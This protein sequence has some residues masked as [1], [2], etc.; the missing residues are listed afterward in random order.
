MILK[1]KGNEVLIDKEDYFLILK[2]K[3]WGFN[4][5]YLCHYYKKLRRTKLLFF[6]RIVIHAPADK[7]VDHINGCKLDNRKVNLRICSYAQNARNLAKIEGGSSI[8]KGVCYNKKNNKWRAYINHEGKQVHLGDFET[9][10]EAA[11]AYNKKAI[12][13]HKEYARINLIVA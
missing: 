6:H 3:S 9:E 1:I 13:L 7:E 10:V 11:L 12:D 4:H 8:Y 5:G 2:Y